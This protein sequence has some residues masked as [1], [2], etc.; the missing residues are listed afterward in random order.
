VDASGDFEG[1]IALVTEGGKRIG[2]TACVELARRGA[3]VAVNYRGDVAASEETTALVRDPGHR[4]YR[5]SRTSATR[6]R[7]N[8][9]WARSALTWSPSTCRSTTR[10]GCAAGVS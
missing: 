8:G 9:R 1:R 6:T 5:H 7:P 3:D 2:R 10:V 4:P